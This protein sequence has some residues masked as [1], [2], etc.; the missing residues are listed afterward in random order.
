M[1]TTFIREETGASLIEYGLL[2]GLISVVAITAVSRLGSKINT[3][4]G[5]VVTTLN[6]QSL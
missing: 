2:V 1:L 4:F 5:N 6:G 3:V